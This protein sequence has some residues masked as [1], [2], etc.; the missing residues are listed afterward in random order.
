[1][2]LFRPPTRGVA[3][4]ET[5]HLYREILRACRLFTWRN[6]DGQLW[7]DILRFNARK[8]IEQNRNEPN[9]EQVARLILVGRDCLNKTKEKFLEAQKK[10]HNDIERTRNR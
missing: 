6:N 8:E 2:T 3:N 7:S 9:A 5:L 10:L 1:M 4:K